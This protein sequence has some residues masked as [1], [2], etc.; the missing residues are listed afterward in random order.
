MSRIG[1]KPVEIPSG[2]KV[3]V[4]DG[5]ITVEKGSGKLQYRHRPEVS[6][7]V[8]DGKRVVCSIPED[9]QENRVYRSYWGL[10]RAL[11]QTMVEGVT[12]GY[13]KQLEIVGVGWG[14]KVQG[15]KLVLSLG[16]CHPVELTIPAGL[17]VTVE[18]SI[19]TIKGVD[20]QAVGQFAALA[21]SKRPPEP[22]NGK[23]VKYVNE[24]IIRKEGKQVVGR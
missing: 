5:T 2:V 18:R 16:Y 12:K 8:E 15:N 20:K 4:A 19:V 21:R 17:D 24:Q 10:T 14:A 23:G 22:Y 7:S 3:A 11:V 13:Q 6:V 1:K 9:Q